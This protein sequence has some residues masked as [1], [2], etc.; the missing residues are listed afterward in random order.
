MKQIPLYGLV[1][2]IFTF[3]WYICMIS[4]LLLHDQHIADYYATVIYIMFKHVHT[5]AKVI[6][7]SH[8]YPTKSHK[9][10]INTS[11]SQC[12]YTHKDDEV[13]LIG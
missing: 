8:V 5:L 7:N 13:D 10:K 1:I 4:D 9:N 2:G 12:T 3:D 6:V 11:L